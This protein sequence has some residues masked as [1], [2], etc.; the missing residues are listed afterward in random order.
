M[1]PP[2]N[3]DRTTT[4]EST[5]PRVDKDERKLIHNE[6]HGSHTSTPEQ[7]QLEGFTTLASQESTTVQD[8]KPPSSAGSHK[9]QEAILQQGQ[10]DAKADS[11]DPDPDASLLFA[12]PADLDTAHLFSGV[13]TAAP[14]SFFAGLL[15]LQNPADIV[16]KRRATTGTIERSEDIPNISD[17]TPKQPPRSF[18]DKQTGIPT[19]LPMEKDSSLSPVKTLAPPELHQGFSA[20]L[21]TFNS[22]SPPPE[23]SSS[24]PIHINLSE[25]RVMNTSSSRTIYT[26]DSNLYQQ[27]L[28]LQQHEQTLTHLP[29][30]DFQ[31]AHLPKDVSLQQYASS[32]SFNG[33]VATI[34][35][36]D[37]PPNT[38]SPFLQDQVS[39]AP[40]QETKATTADIMISHTTTLPKSDPISIDQP[41]NKAF[42]LLHEYTPP[43]QV[44]FPPQAQSSTPHMDNEMPPTHQPAETSF[45]TEKK[46]ETVDQ[47][48]SLHLSHPALTSSDLPIPFNE[49][50]S[51]PCSPVFDRE[52]SAAFSPSGTPRSDL[53]GQPGSYSIMELGSE[54]ASSPYFSHA[55]QSPLLQEHHGEQ[56][57][58]GFSSNSPRWIRQQ[59]ETEG[60]GFDQ[61]SLNEDLTATTPKTSSPPPKERGLA[62]FLDPSTLSAVEDL[63]NMP[64]SAAFERGMSRLFQG[65]KSSA[66]SIFASP[67]AHVHSKLP[68][69][70]DQ[71]REKA[72]EMS[73]SPKIEPREENDD[74]VAPSHLSVFETGQ[75]VDLPPMLGDNLIVDSSEFTPTPPG[76]V[77]STPDMDEQQPAP[78]ALPLETQ[79]QSEETSLSRQQINHDW[80]YSQPSL[81][82]VETFEQTSHETTTELSAYDTFSTLGSSATSGTLSNHDMTRFYDSS[83]F[84]GKQSAILDL[85]PSDQIVADENIQVAIVP[86]QELVIVATPGHGHDWT[87]PS[88]SQEE[89]L[90]TRGLLNTFGPKRT[91]Q[92][93]PEHVLRGS[94]EQA[95]AHRMEQ[96]SPTNR[97]TAENTKPDHLTRTS[98]AVQR[99]SSPSVLD[100]EAILRKQVAVSALLTEQA[101]KGGV[102]ASAETK[103]KLLGKAREL[104][105]KRQA[106]AGNYSPTLGTHAVSTR[107]S[108]PPVMDL[109]SSPRVSV[110]SNGVS[111]DLGG[112]ISTTHST[113]TTT[114]TSSVFAHVWPDKTVHQAS[115][116]STSTEGERAL[117]VHHQE[118]Q[119][120]SVQV[121]LGENRQLKQQID[122][123]LDKVKVLEGGHVQITSMEFQNQELHCELEDLRVELRMAQ[124]GVEE[125]FS[126]HS[127][128]L[129]DLTK[130]NQRLESDA[131]HAWRIV[132]EQ[133]ANSDLSIKCQRLEGDLE[134][135]L[136][137]IR[138][139]Q[140]SVGDLGRLS[141]ENE[142]LRQELHYT[143][144][145]LKDFSME[146]ARRTTSPTN[147]STS[148]DLLTRE[149][150]GLRRQLK[151]QRAEMKELQ[152]TVKRSES[153]KREL[154]L[155]IENLERSLED[156][157]KHR[158]DLVSQ[159]VMKDEAYRTI[160]EK[161]VSS[162]EEEK[163]QYMDEEAFK[164]AKLEVRFS[165]LQDEVQRLRSEQEDKRVEAIQSTEQLS[166]IEDRLALVSSIAALKDRVVQLETMLVT[167]QDL[168]ANHRLRVSELESKAEEV[169]KNE[170]YLNS[171]LSSLREHTVS[172]QQELDETRESH[173]TTLVAVGEAAIIAD[174]KIKLDSLEQ[175]LDEAFL[176]ESA[177]KNELELALLST[178]R[179]RIDEGSSSLQQIEYDRALERASKWQEDCFA[180]QEEKMLIEDQLQRVHMELM[181]ARTEISQLEAS[182]ESTSGPLSSTMIHEEL[183]QEL[184]ETRA[185]LET[186]KE[187]LQG[188]NVAF[189]SSGQEHAWNNRESDVVQEVEFLQSERIRL[190][191]EL[192]AA[193]RMD[194]TSTLR[195]QEVQMEQLQALM[196]EEKGAN[197]ERV[198]ELNRQ[199]KKTRELLLERQKEVE[200]LMLDLDNI[201]FKSAATERELVSLQQREDLLYRNQSTE[202]AMLLQSQLD[203]LSRTLVADKE[204]A[205]STVENQKEQVEKQL[206]AQSGLVMG[207]RKQV[208]I[209]Q[210][211]VRTLEQDLVS[212]TDQIHS[213]DH[214]S[215]LVAH[216]LAEI[217]TQTKGLQDESRQ[218]Q[219]QMK[220]VVGLFEK[221]L[222]LSDDATEADALDDTL[223]SV[224]AGME[225]LG[226]PTQSFRRV[227][228][229]FI[230]LHKIVA[231]TNNKVY[232]LETELQRMKRRSDDQDDRKS[233]H[234]IVS[235]SQAPPPQS[236]TESHGPGRDDSEVK[237]LREKLAKAEQGIGKLQ[238]F[239]Q[240]FQNEKKMAIYDL[241]QRLEHSAKEVI[242]SRS[243]LAKAQ[244][245]LLSRPSN[246]GTPTRGSF[247]LELRSP[248]QEKFPQQ[249]QQ[250][251]QQPLQSPSTT[252]DIRNVLTDEM[253][254]GTEQIHHEAVLALEPLRQQKAELERTLLDLRHRYE[255]SQKENDALLS[256]LEK[257]NQQLKTKTDKM[258]PDMASEHLERIHE[259]ELEQIELSRQL[260]TAQREREFTRQDMKA[261]KAELA[262]LKA[263]S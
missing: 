239:L 92:S 48:F 69:D 47:L 49:S 204:A 187:E 63:L 52:F 93:T 207:L 32:T 89:S 231:D 258:S 80:N 195:D 211:T 233:T 117:A 17:D 244:A 45:Q 172:L 135:A 227:G 18:S 114:T 121:L 1:S 205:V 148:S 38:L 237:E 128:Q 43:R 200:Q 224:L 225:P 170:E 203:E 11:R 180:A 102:R 90:N 94:P 171:S 143:Q 260:K 199:L 250:Q 16:Q 263:R 154:V 61:V 163:A 36:P 246:P 188:R 12:D 151:G 125:S 66:T 57:T 255:Q 109:G 127:R 165:Q 21:H 167:A 164:L 101:G 262:K 105:E 56:A 20:F 256:E 181:A 215:G 176:R 120:D 156:A 42:S 137:T 140:V 206:E 259:L 22:T 202:S 75:R 223:I 249:Q 73:S 62:S 194:N 46:T 53:T 13:T 241:E 99:P 198:E 197:L 54:L 138:S 126:R 14:N 30:E 129:D 243:Q 67:L 236:E 235:I 196:N 193:R 27:P 229:R 149:A 41:P 37:E 83:L 234:S 59:F 123:L 209:L 15:S 64:K 65:V 28:Q 178:G 23:T 104:L 190:E 44:A 166:T 111:L 217:E 26:E 226:V 169:R 173:A 192:E 218:A 132:R 110:E 210:E 230:E 33:N 147:E 3:P 257:E 232:E 139:Y 9:P 247:Q 72:H 39:S 31:Q 161:L 222:R 85:I 88:S 96:G 35:H 136:N 175:E 186:L 82:Q 174:Q 219:E 24:S 25:T 4:S 103:T 119:Q 182:L 8:D 141:T 160:Q 78:V 2:Q 150:E 179:E 50:L 107:Q 212:A 238:Q 58:L 95:T 124:V 84:I 112:G 108:S 155:K 189:I 7:R 19:F 146:Q 240:E 122:S 51:G 245:M 29:K 115:A 158:N 87:V 91:V 191:S 253:F 100:R 71:G 55:K 34:V 40:M 60:S 254:K 86:P 70:S 144:Q 261:L 98:F 130:E 77:P 213:K 216:Q 252:V 220:L 214:S 76:F 168:E 5:S 145:Q 242:Q 10:Q 153:E 133:D 248:M 183:Q 251:Q 68:T 152:D 81:F 201:T 208:D 157:A 184:E 142:Q 118:H 185:Q 131:A 97:F 162:F 74:S 79:I 106:K 116:P 159:Q 113:T 228:T 177:L 221:L 6:Q 134:H